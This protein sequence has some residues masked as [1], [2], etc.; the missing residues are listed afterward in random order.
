MANGAGDHPTGVGVNKIFTKGDVDTRYTQ[1]IFPQ[2]GTPQGEE[3][4]CEGSS[5]DDPGT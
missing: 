4:L 2:H 1:G 5:F 3:S